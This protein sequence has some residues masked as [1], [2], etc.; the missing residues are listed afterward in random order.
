MGT[1]RVARAPAESAPTAA[2]PYTQVTVLRGE[3]VDIVTGKSTED[4]TA[5]R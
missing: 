3:E 1:R 4:E 5:D 2:V